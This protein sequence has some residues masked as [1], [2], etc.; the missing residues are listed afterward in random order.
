MRA[1]LAAQGCPKV[2]L[3]VRGSNA[4]ALEFYARLGYEPSDVATLGRRLVSDE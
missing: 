3:M 2:K 4:A 1:L